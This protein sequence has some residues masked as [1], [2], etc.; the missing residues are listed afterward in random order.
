MAMLVPLSIDQIEVDAPVPVAIWDA[1]GKLLLRSGDVIRS[2]KERE[3]IG[4]HGPHVRAADYKAWV[5]GYTS[6]LDQMVRNNRS[7]QDIAQT[8]LPSDFKLQQADDAVDSDPI[9]VWPDLHNSVTLLQR[10]SSSQTD[11]ITRLDAVEQRLLRMLIVDP[12]RSLFMV[13]HLLQDP[14]VGYCAAHALA[15]TATV[16]LVARSLDVPPQEQ[17]ALR[18]AALTMNTGI[19]RLMDALSA[20]ASEP[21]PVQR[22]ALIEHPLRSM[23]L[24]HRLGVTDPLWLELVRDHHEMPDGSGY[25][26]GK[27]HPPMLQQILRLADLMCEHLCQRHTEAVATGTLPMQARLMLLDDKG[28][29]SPLG[30]AYLRCMGFHPPGCFVRLANNESAVV[31]RR[32]SRANAPKVLSLVGRHGM[33]LGEPTTRDCADP[34]YEVRSLLPRTSVKVLLDPRKLLARI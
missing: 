27:R 13:M 12:D 20:G 22:E 24:L 34:T 29:P 4:L 3:V 18:R 21:S 9:Q 31:V 30:A 16:S 11:L 25:P 28:Q 2:Q 7:L 14:A 6:R 17:Q 15:V 8:R 1:H 26:A 23:L 5:Y 33:P 10:Q 32:G 19:T